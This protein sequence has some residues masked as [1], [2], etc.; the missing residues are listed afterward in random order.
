MR[1]YEIVFIVKPDFSEEDLDKLIAQMEGV[2]TNTGGS[3]QSVD[4]WGRRRLAYEVRGVREGHYVMFTIDSN[5]PTLREFERVLKVTEPV[6]KFLTVRIDEE[7]KRLD[8]LRKEREKRSAKRRAAAPPPPAP[9]PA[10]APAPAA[11]PAAPD[12][13]TPPA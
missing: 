1:S 9:P 10:P 6:I 5:P 2:V 8:K 13:E 3:V 7:L 12:T 11:A 4:K